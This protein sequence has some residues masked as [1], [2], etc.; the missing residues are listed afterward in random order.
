M[1]SALE[2]HLL[3]SHNH[4]QPKPKPKNHT[5]KNY[6]LIKEKR[7][8]E[9]TELFYIVE[10][11]DGTSDIA[12]GTET[13]HDGGNQDIRDSLR[14]AA[15]NRLEFIHS[16]TLESIFPVEGIELPESVSLG[17]YRDSLGNI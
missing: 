10:N 16:A 4:H 8:A 15:I 17:S 11:G 1:A 5:M 9:K 14:A 13:L 3:R 6:L 7:H 2:T 12:E